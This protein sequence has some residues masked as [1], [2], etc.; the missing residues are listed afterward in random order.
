MV[1]GCATINT[2][3]KTY[4][5]GME[6]VGGNMEFGLYIDRDGI[7]TDFD[8]VTSGTYSAREPAS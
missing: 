8:D 3:E 7:F 5:P 1:A 2:N 4:G 6:P